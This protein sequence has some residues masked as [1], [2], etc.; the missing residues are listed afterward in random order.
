MKAIITIIGSDEIGIIASITTKLAEQEVNILDINQT[1]MQEIFTMIML[2]DLTKLKKNF[3]EFQEELSQEGINKGV[4][5]RIQ[6]EDI[7][8]KMHEL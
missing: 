4:D 6:R 2:V 7:F 8:K 5:V 1:V 3:K